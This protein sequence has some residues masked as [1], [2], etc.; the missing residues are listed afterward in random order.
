MASVPR[1]L[2]Y[3]ATRVHRS[4]YLRRDLLLRPLE[5]ARGN[6]AARQEQL[7]RIES[8]TMQSRN[9]PPSDR[10]I[11]IEKRLTMR[12]NDQPPLFIHEGMDPVPEPKSTI[13]EI[14]D[15][16]KAA[17]DFVQGAIDAGRRPGMPLSI[18]SNIAREAPLSSLF[19]A[20]MLGIAAGHRR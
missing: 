11:E 2:P 14:S 12:D 16:I 5:A 17:V 19:V 7:G 6:A 4:T 9:D 20:F 15:A 8:K 1:H 13:A 18:L 10:L 3:C